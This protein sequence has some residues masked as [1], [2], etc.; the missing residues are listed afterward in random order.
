LADSGHAECAT[1]EAEFQRRIE[2]T[3]QKIK[4]IAS[5]IENGMIMNDLKT[6]LEE[7][8]KEGLNCLQS[9]LNVK[10][11][12]ALDADLAARIILEFIGKFQTYI[13]EVNR[14][15]RKQLLRACMRQTIVDRESNQIRCFVRKIPLVHPLPAEFEENRIKHETPSVLGKGLRTKLAAGTRTLFKSQPQ[16]S[17]SFT[18]SFLRIPKCFRRLSASNQGGKSR[19]IV[20]PNDLTL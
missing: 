2:A 9:F 14:P 11:T 8:N 10:E 19:E 12:K 4:N 17:L 1:Q 7:L 15:T 5:A 13:E 18:S 16:E 6:R 3:G 20:S